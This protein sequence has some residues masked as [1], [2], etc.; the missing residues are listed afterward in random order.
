MILFPACIPTP[1]ASLLFS[2]SLAQ[3][4]H[5]PLIPGLTL[6]T[7]SQE[8]SPCVGRDPGR[9]NECIMN[10][11][12]AWR[13]SLW[14]CHAPHRPCCTLSCLLQSSGWIKALGVTPASYEELHQETQ[15]DVRCLWLHNLLRSLNDLR[16]PPL[17]SDVSGW[18]APHL[19]SGR[20]CSGES[21]K[22]VP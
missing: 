10:H 14:P 9:R 2:N 7:L 15:T 16:P 18:C 19:S 1:T 12:L 21:N 22:G 3:F 17:V 5:C 20:P 11:Y 4:P 13:H 6:H 8:S